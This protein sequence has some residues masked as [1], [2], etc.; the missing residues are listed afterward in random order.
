MPPWQISHVHTRSPFCTGTFAAT[1]CRDSA[2][3][4]PSVKG[5]FGNFHAA[6]SSR[7]LDESARPAIVRNILGHVDIRVTQ[8]VDR[9]SWWK[10]FPDEPETRLR[11]VARELLI[12]AA[13]STGRR[14]TF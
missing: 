3:A 8:N 14:N 7:M 13:S 11:R 5:Y 12:D 2:P 1:L 9:K 4:D 10:G 6:H